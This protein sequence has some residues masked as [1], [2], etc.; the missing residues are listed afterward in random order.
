MSNFFKK[1]KVSGEV[2]VAAD[3]YKEVREGLNKYLTDNIGKSAPKYTG[4]MVA[5]MTGQEDRSLQTL[6][7]YAN[8]TPASTSTAARQQAEDTLSGKYSDPTKSPVY[9]AMKAESMRNLDDTM[10]SIA[11][12]K[13]GGGHFWTGARLGEQKDAAVDTTNQ[14]NTVMGQL[15][16]N[17][18]NRQ[19]GM[20]SVA[21]ILG[22]REETA[23][24]QTTAALQQ[25]G[26]LPRIIQ[27]AIDDA[28]YNEHL[29]KDYE[30]PMQ[31]AQIAAGVQQA[32]LYS[33]VGYAP[34]MFQKSM[35][36][37]MSGK[38]IYPAFY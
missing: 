17:E 25:Y 10:E 6:D 32:P 31:I 38:G 11:D 1:K 24:L 29:T 15:A 19:T 3:P 7:A 22:E 30:F 13:A 35:E 18:R 34:S 9:Q 33:Q 36:G 20:V 21:D 26:S 23:P 4:E 8:R 2:A 5:P 16:E 37:I 14:L 27:Q 28:A 12:T